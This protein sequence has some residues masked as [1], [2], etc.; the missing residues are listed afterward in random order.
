M[1]SSNDIIKQAISLG[2]IATKNILSE[3]AKLRHMR[4]LP[5]AII[6][7]AYKLIDVEAAGASSATNH[8][9]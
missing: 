6:L 3:H 1:P 8:A 5:E 7:C 2:I 9:S 4:V